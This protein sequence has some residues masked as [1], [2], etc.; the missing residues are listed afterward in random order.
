MLA[1]SFNN[2][3]GLIANG[4]AEW[5]GASWSAF[6]GGITGFGS[7]SNE[8]VTYGDSI[9]LGGGFGEVDGLANTEDI[10]I[11]NGSNWAP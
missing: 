4:V 9:V 6:G 1:G 3:G 2:I 11:W 8:V 10:A 7:G 5:N